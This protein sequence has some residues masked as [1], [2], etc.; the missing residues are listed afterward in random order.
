MS[1]EKAS[2]LLRYGLYQFGETVFKNGRMTPYTVRLPQSP[3]EEL[4][5]SLANVA[6]D[7]EVL[8]A[9]QSAHCIGIANSGVP[10]A[11]AIHEY[12]LSTGRHAEFSIVY[13]REESLCVGLADKKGTP[14]LIDNAVTTGE[15]V[16]TVLEMVRRFG[17]KPETV[18]RIFDRE[19]V[20]EDGLSTVERVKAQTGLNLVSIFQL[21]DIIPCLNP[22]ERQAV[23]WY[24][25]A[26]GTTSFK[27][28]TG[29]QN[30]L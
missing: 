28:W 1:P 10:L 5:R 29:V 30:V 18:I 2:C 8:V 16:V 22:E 25:S 21:R 20:G 14:V 17:Y 24:Q 4:F 12:G 7:L 27:T 15:T 23:L 9:L 3:Q 26:Y 13:P 6:W 19:D 11:R